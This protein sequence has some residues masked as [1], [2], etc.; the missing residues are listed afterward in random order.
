MPRLTFRR[1]DGHTGI[2]GTVTTAT[3]ADDADAEAIADACEDGGVTWRR[4]TA[5]AALR[6]RDFT[7]LWSGM[8][9]SNIGTWMQT[10]VLT[11]YGLK[12]GDKAFV[13]Y[14]GFAVLGPLLLLA[15]VS[16][17]LADVVDRRRFLLA[18]QTLQLLGAFGL[19]GY[20]TVDRPS[21]LVIWII[22][23][24]IGVTNALTGPAM[25]A[26][27]PSLVPKEDL[28]GA[29]SLFSF[30]MNMSRVVG[31]L[32]GAPIYV[33]FGP[34]PVFVVNAVTYLFAMA[35]LILAKYPRRTGAVISET[36]FARLASGFRIAWHDP[37]VRRVLLILWSLSLLSLNFI[38]F[39]SGHAQDN[40][41]IPAKSDAYGALYACFGLGAAAGAM[42]VGTV[43]ARFDKAAMIRPAFVGM[44]GALL[45]FGLLQSSTPAYPIVLVL[46]FTYFVAITALST[47]MQAN[48]TDQV[49]GRVMSLWIMGFGGAVGLASLMWA[50]V[51]KWSV[52]FVLIFG[53]AWTLLLAVNSK[54]NLLRR[55]TIDD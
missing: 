42:S 9:A 19:A 4:G 44:A 7:I 43:F 46:G 13:G 31:P 20:V 6:H 30:Q 53:A 23:L 25:S 11:Q 22:V 27:S 24:L 48:I 14:L 37:L 8:F 12:I 52:S 1:G 15:P 36:G 55:E 41:D 21:K 32:I 45:I 3:R 39:M 2:V 10:I 35:G 26:I 29:I 40:L 47:V 49:R 50:P 51:A 33:R 18:M 16:G 54:P 28:P 5:R 17:V 34:A 38:Q